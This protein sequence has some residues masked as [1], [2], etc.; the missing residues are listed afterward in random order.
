[1]EE[2]L[3]PMSNNKAQAAIT[4]ILSGMYDRCCLSTAYTSGTLQTVTSHAI[5]IELNS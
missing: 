2:M 4:A 1:V 3:A 5:S